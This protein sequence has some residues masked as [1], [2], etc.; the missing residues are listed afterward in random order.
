MQLGGVMENVR[1]AKLLGEAISSLLSSEKPKRVT[2]IP[3]CEEQI[4][5]YLLVMCQMVSYVDL[6]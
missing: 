5:R 6:C 1:G 3:L 4:I 2:E